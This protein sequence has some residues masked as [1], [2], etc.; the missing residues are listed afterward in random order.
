MM[1]DNRIPLVTVGI[2]TFNRP[3]GLERTLQCII[4]Q[5]YKNVEIIVSDNCSTDPTVLTLLNKFAAKD[6]RIRFIVQ[7]QNISIVP[8]FQFLLDQASGEYFMWAADDDFWENNFIETC[9]NGMLANND[10]V[11]CMTDLNIVGLEGDSKRS[12][13]NRGF[14]QQNIFSRCFHFVKSTDE[15]KYFF[16]GLY[17]TA[18]VKN[19][20]F[21]NN[22]G[23]DHMFI[24]EA[25]IKGKFLYLPNQSCFYY[26]RGGSS[27]NMDRVRKAFNITNRFYFFE[28]Y[29]LKYMT[30]QFGFKHLGIFK[31]AGLFLSNGLGL[32]FNED[33]ILYYI[34]IKKPVKTL[35]KKLK[36]KKP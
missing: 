11:L 19:I 27:T 24:Y 35:F 4:D 14:M 10:V 8:N 21:N 6:H 20:P 13:L 2:P 29:Y 31:K 33:Y 30:Y 36:G 5:T 12:K 3:Q 16:C 1:N 34:F 9:V 18:L 17:R 26:F 15:N 28:A 25:L 7:Q 32:I 23:G 22:W